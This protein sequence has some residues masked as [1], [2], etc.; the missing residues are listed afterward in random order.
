MSQA[1]LLLLSVGLESRLPISP[2][3]SALLVSMI[4]LIGRDNSI[5]RH[6]VHGLY[7]L[8]GI[9]MLPLA[10]YEDTYTILSVSILIFD[11]NTN[12]TANDFL[13]HAPIT[14]ELILI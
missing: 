13:H 11:P 7:C 14:M 9:L 10:R 2:T 1:K 6:G 8:I 5:A 12:F 4:G 3:V